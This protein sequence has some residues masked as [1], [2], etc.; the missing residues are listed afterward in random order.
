MVKYDKAW[1][2]ADLAD[3]MAEYDEETKLLKKWSE[4]SDVVYTCSRGRWSGYDTEFPYKMW[5]FYSGLIYMFP[6]YTL[7]WLFYR[8]AG[9]KIGTTKD[10]HEVRNP[11][12][13]EKLNQIAERN[14]VDPKK[15]AEICKKQLKYWPLIP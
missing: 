1:H 11:K 14:N 8:S 4:L 5:Q 13:I 7:R 2:I 6:K 15:F 12:K 3:E 9:R 10:I